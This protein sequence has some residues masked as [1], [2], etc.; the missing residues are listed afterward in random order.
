[1]YMHIMSQARDAAYRT[2]LKHLGPGL[3]KMARLADTLYFYM[4]RLP[5]APPARENS[6]TM[7]V[8]FS[9]LPVYIKYIHC[10][11]PDSPI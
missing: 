4:S 8:H 3:H 2:E 9:I 1:M 5:T 11:T 10:Q 7:S 6:F